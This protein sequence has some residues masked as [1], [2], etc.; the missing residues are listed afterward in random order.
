M[1]NQSQINSI[2]KGLLSAH[3]V[4]TASENDWFVPNGQ[5]PAIR[6]FW[7]V[8][9]NGQSGRLDVQVMVEQD[10][11]LE[12]CFAG[13]G[14]GV[15]ALKDA[16]QNFILNDFHVLLAAFWGQED[17]DQVLVEPWSTDHAQYTLYLGQTGTRGSKGVHVE[18]SEDIWPQLN[19]ALKKSELNDRCI[20]GRSFFCNIGEQDRVHEALL[21]NEAWSEGEQALKSI[22]WPKS[23]GY[24]SVRRFWILKKE[25]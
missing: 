17:P 19:Q 7:Q 21:N 8:S 13:I 14:S 10:V 3:G 22:D 6:C 25:L 1:I 9:E 23:A 4:D 24:Y 20:W 18:L 12:E 16:F 11:I 15:E 2:L 5:L